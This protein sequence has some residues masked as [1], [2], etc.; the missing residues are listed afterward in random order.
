MSSMFQVTVYHFYVMQMAD[1]LT[2]L[3]HA[4]QVMNFLKTLINK[5]LGEREESAAQGSR[6]LLPCTDSPCNRGDSHPSNL[7]MGLSCG[8]TSDGCSIEGRAVGYPFS[9]TTLDRLESDGM[10]ESGVAG[11]KM[12]PKRGMNQFLTKALLSWAKG[13]IRKMV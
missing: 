2:A 4:V 6:S 1:P 7:R 3:I 12:M 11:V 8:Q 5:T 13:E 9:S 10:E